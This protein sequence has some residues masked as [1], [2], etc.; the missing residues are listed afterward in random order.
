MTAMADLIRE[1]CKGSETDYEVYENYTKSWTTPIGEE[2]VTT[3]G[4]VVKQGRSPMDALAQLTGFLEAKEVFD[5]R[6]LELEGTAIDD[7]GPD[8]VVYFPAIQDYHPMQE[9]G[10]KT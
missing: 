5:E 7:L 1:F 2:T 9:R 4:I 3:I 10:V 8:A 6:L